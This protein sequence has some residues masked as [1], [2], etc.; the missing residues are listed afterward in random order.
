MAIVG[1]EYGLSVMEKGQ[2]VLWEAQF[3]DFANCAQVS[4]DQFVSSGWE[5]WGQTASLVLL[6]PHGYEGQGPEHSSARLER[7][8]QLCAENNIRVVSPTT[9]ANYFHLL[10]L[11]ALTEP[12]RPLVVMNPKSLLRHPK[13]TSTVAEITEGGFQPVIDDLVVPD[14][15]AIERLVLCTGKVYYDL[16]G[17]DLRED[18]K[19]TAI[20]RVEELYPFPGEDLAVMIAGYPNLKEVVWVQEEPRNMG[21]LSYIGPRLRGVTPRTISLQHVARPERASPAEGKHI[22]HVVEQARVLR[23]A[24]QV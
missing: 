8:L 16:I 19:T 21:A 18:A 22:D 24:L 1:F 7:F 17:S 11:Q 14:K 15:S 10:R 12:Q 9:P 20:A 13:A 4:I 2:L 5:K 6:L 23:E 3:G